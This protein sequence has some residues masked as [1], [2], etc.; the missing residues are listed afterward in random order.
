MAKKLTERQIVYV[1]LKWAEESMKEMLSGTQPND[2]IHINTKNRLEQLVTYRE[3]KYGK[4]KDPFDNAKNIL[5]FYL[6]DKK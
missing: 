1:A 4:E 6:M 5:L 2:T 3:K